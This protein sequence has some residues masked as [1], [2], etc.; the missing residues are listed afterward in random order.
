MRRVILLLFLVLAGLACA[1]RVTPTPAPSPAATEATASEAG[2]KEVVNRFLLGGWVMPKGDD[3]RADPFAETLK[4]FVIT[5][6]KE[7]RDFLDGINLVRARGNRES[8]NGVASNEEMVLAAYYLWR[9]VKGDPLSIE[10]VTLKETDVEVGLELLQDPQG[11]ESPYL[12]AP[13]SIVAV[14][15]EDLPRGVPLRF[16]F[17]VNGEVT[18]T[19]TVTLK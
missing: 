4:A 1:T 10:R 2:G 15:K 11:R 9:P 8:L 13:L 14:G 19:Q 17:L 6:E 16:V 7:L 12:M 3:A 18:A 5:T